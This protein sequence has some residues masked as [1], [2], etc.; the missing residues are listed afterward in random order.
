MKLKALALGL[1]A[2]GVTACVS[3]PPISEEDFP[4]TRADIALRSYYKTLESLELPVA[5][6]SPAFNANASVKRI[7]V[8]SCLNEER[9]APALAAM[10]DEDAEITFLIGDN[11]YGDMDGR[12]YTN[13]DPD[14]VEVRESYAELSARED[15]K[16]LRAA[17]PMMTTWD[18]HDYGANDAGA[19]FPFREFAERIYETYWGVTQTEAGSRPGIYDSVISGPEGERLQIIMLDTRYFR[20]PLTRTDE[21]GAVG[22]ER[23]LPSED[24]YQ[25]ML[26]EAQWAWLKDELEKP[27]D[28][29][30]LVS[31]I[32]I[33][34]DVHGYEAWSRM[35]KE[36][37]RLY[38]LMK[39]TD[40]AKNTVF[41]SGDRHTAFLYENTAIEAGPVYEITTS[42]IN[43]AFA[44]AEIPSEH[45][46]MEVGRGYTQENYGVIEID[47]D[48][49]QV[50]L[51]IKDQKGMIVR[52]TVSKF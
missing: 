47:W 15:F 30:L 43:A 4:V 14:L 22:K 52:Q 1:F 20:T 46:P 6:A 24:P 41:V 36:R 31:S 16:A 11:V 33:T 26:G 32:Q 19:D 39:S 35:P 3:K 25:S 44:R 29:R 10:T 51:Q 34:P 23:Y 45:D 42:S 18:D 12:F 38:Q 9:D 48:D 17:R 5:P 28:L 49:R 13:N 50:A 7:V 27:A 21:Y 2:V 37:D 40:A 8:G